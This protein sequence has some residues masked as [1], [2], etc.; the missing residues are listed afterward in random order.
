MS[1]RLS[2]TVLPRPYAAP[3]R[4]AEPCLSLEEA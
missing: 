4:V 3:A 2:E 1:M